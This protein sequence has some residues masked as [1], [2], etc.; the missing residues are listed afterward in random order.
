MNLLNIKLL[1]AMKYCPKNRKGD[2]KSRKQHS[3][4]YVGEGVYHFSYENGGF[5]ANKGELVYIPKGSRHH[6]EVVDEKSVCYQIEFEMETT[7]FSL[8]M[9]PIKLEN[10]DKNLVLMKDAVLYFNTGLLPDYFI[11]L[12]KLCYLCAD[13]TKQIN[14]KTRKK[15]RILPALEYL[16][17]HCHEKIELSTLSELCHLSLSQLRRIFAKEI[18]TTPT[19]YKNSLRIE[20][21]KRMLCNE[22]V[23]VSQVAQILGFEN[24]YVFSNT[25]K[26][27]AGISPTQFIKTLNNPPTGDI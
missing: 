14:E 18:N 27:Y 5:Y 15:S 26:K 23:N 4:L 25:F 21:A 8:P 1:W 6:F 7:D 10:N 3:F 11:S 17:E 16:E 24:I 9:H 22:D 2:V 20:K 13:M 19:A 12:G